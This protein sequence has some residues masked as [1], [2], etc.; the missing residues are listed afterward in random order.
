MLKPMNAKTVYPDGRVTDSMLTAGQLA[1]GRQDFSEH[2]D[3]NTLERLS[4]KRHR[5]ALAR[6]LP[7]QLTSSRLPNTDA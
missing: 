5:E 7:P 6:K 4:I 2:F 1:S 3:P